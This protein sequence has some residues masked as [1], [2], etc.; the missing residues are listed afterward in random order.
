V[1]Y[2][3]ESIASRDQLIAAAADDEALQTNRRGIAYARHLLS[4]ALIRQGEVAD[5]RKQ[6]E[7]ALELM[8]ACGDSRGISLILNNRGLDAK[9]SGAYVRAQELFDEA[10]DQ[11]TTAR[12]FAT[13]AEVR[14]NLATVYERRGNLEKAE[15]LYT[16]SMSSLR[17]AG[18][19]LSVASCLSNLARIARLSG[20][21]DE[22]LSFA[23]QALDIRKE[24]ND[25]DAIS[26]SL[27]QISGILVTTWQAKAAGGAA[28]TRGLLEEAKD[29]S[30]EALRIATDASYNR[31]IANAQLQLADVLMIRRQ[32]DAAAPLYARAYVAAGKCMDDQIQVAVVISWSNCATA[33]DEEL[34][35]VKLLR[36]ARRI[37]WRSPTIQ[38]IRRAAWT[39][40]APPTELRR[41]T[42]VLM[43]LHRLLT[44]QGD[45][46]R[47]RSG[48]ALYA[49]MRFSEGH[50]CAFPNLGEAYEKWAAHHTD[51]VERFKRRAARLRKRMAPGGAFDIPQFGKK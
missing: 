41:L 22:A 18:R 39:E 48:F 24:F 21:L 5:G 51:L 31:G 2:L 35:A 17:K 14:N 47:M 16:E 49:A 30:E 4:V 1:R 6:A 38:S 50:G 3:N 26:L 20:K 12:D 40:A 46:E 29:A 8:R 36:L 43:E 44:R 11:A 45:R 7:T 28:M 9:S 25:L 13:L 33:M 19:M 34:V 23:R 10:L 27:V 37:L 15:H 42:E 32:F